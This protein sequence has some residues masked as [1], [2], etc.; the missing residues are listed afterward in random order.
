MKLREW[1]RSTDAVLVKILGSNAWTRRLLQWVPSL[2]RLAKYASVG[3]LGILL[4]MIMLVLL[5]EGV[6][7]YY[8]HSALISLIIS[9]Y[10]LYVSHKRFTFREDGE[11]LL[12]QYVKYITISIM[13]ICVNLTLLYFITEIVGL[14]YVI[15]KLFSIS[16]SFGVTFTLTSRLFRGG[17]QV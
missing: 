3:A 17:N 13:G 6:G 9:D 8:M 1:S 4:D 2:P 10:V 15:S 14:C 7:I 5:T 16:G 12:S 11:L